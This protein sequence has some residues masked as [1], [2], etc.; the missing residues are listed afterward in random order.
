[1][2]SLFDTVQDYLKLERIE[3]AGLK[4]KSLLTMVENIYEEFLK[5]YQHFAELP[6]EVLTPEEEEFSQDLQ[7]FFKEVSYPLCLR[8]E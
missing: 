3:I 7:K 5:L 2:Q 8:I 4:G 6:Y 1:M